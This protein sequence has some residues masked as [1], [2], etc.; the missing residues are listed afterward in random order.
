VRL[1]RHRRTEAADSPRLPG[2]A[3]RRRLSRHS[4]LEWSVRK[5][6]EVTENGRCK[7]RCSRSEGAFDVRGGSDKLSNSDRAK[8]PSSPLLLVLGAAMLWSTGGLFIKATQLSPLG[9]S[10]GRSLLAAITIAIFTRR[11]GLDLNRIIALN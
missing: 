8:G 7:G 4:T 11:E 6:S 5:V 9:L 3:T 2:P 10:F 1:H